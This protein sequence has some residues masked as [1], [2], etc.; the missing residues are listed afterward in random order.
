MSKLAVALVLLL[1]LSIVACGD[2]MQYEKS[3]VEILFVDGSLA[4]KT[5]I[6]YQPILD[7]MYYCP[8]ANIRHEADR[9]K[10]FFLRCKINNVCPVDVSA[11]KLGQG[12]WKLVISSTPDKLDLV[13]RDGEIQLPPKN[14]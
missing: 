9:Q 1:S 7:S 8:G 3:N 13:F 2:T 11:E 4:G 6:T 12:Q 5:Q 10:V 14:K